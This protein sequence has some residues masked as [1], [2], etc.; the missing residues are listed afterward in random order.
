MAVAAPAPDES[1]LTPAMQAAF[2]RLRA[3]F[4]AGLPA[5]L[6]EIGRAAAAGEV[7]GGQAALHRLAGAAGGYGFA[8]LGTAA[9]RAEQVLLAAGEAPFHQPAWQAAWAALQA[10]SATVR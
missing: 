4:L 10:E 7:A 2:L 1:G 3:Q 5:R 8:D 6:D 9:R